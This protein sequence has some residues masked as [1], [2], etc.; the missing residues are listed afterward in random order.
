M[1][2]ATRGLISLGFIGRQAEQTS[3]QYFS[4]ASASVP[5][6]LFLPGV[7]FLTSLDDDL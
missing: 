1:G 2:S 5:V 6:T 4:V 7:P 3:K